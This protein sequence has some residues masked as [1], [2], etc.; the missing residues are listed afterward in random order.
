MAG[1]DLGITGGRDPY[2]IGRP[3]VVGDRP[4]ALH[5][6]VG[7][8]GEV[9]VD[10][11]PPIGVVDTGISLDGGTLPAWAVGRV[12]YDPDTDVDRID[13]AAASGLA[14]HG[15]FVSALILGQDPL[16]RILMKAAVDD[17]TAGE[18]EDGKV[19]AAIRALGAETKLINLSFG[20]R[21]DESV[22][23]KEIRDAIDELDESVVVVAAAGNAAVARR[24]FPAGLRPKAALMVSVGATDETGATPLVAD[25]SN[26]WPTLS[27]FACGVDVRGPHPGQATAVRSGTSIAAALVTGRISR[28]ARELGTDMRTAAEQLLR[29]PD[30]ELAVWTVNGQHTTPYLYV[31]AEVVDLGF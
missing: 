17:T 6:A 13:V 26:V 11:P 7:P 8:V 25:F 20:G 12:E 1:I 22:P 3:I 2:R 27:V 19:A 14:Y 23:P 29:A 28:A 21:A 4:F 30:R 5:L 10:A 16:A 31:E 18:D 24:V 9:V 15:T